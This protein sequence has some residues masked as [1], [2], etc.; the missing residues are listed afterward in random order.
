MPRSG[1]TLLKSCGNEP[2]VLTKDLLRFQLRDGRIVPTLLKPTPGHLALAGSL[3]DHWNGGVGKRLGELEDEAVPLLHESRALVVARGLQKLVLDRCRFVDAASAEHLRREALLASA[4][5]LRAPA[6]DADAHRAAIADGLGLDSAALAE[7]LYGDL[8][9][10]A[11]LAAGPDLDPGD[12]LAQYNLALCQGLLTHASELRITVHDAATGLRRKL[13]KALRWRRLLAHI[14]GDD[15]AAL[16]LVVSGPG[17]VLDQATRYGLQLALFLP[18]LAC[19]KRWS[20]AAT[21]KVPRVGGGSAVLT[22]DHTLDLPGDSAFLGHVP[23]ELRDLTTA[24]AAACPEWT[25]E[26][27]QLMPLSDGEIVVSD[28]QLRAD[29]A[30]WRIELFHRWHG[31][32]LARRLTQIA[33]GQ[34]PGLLLGVDRALARTAAVA[35]LLDD[36]LF[37]RRGFLFS[38]LLTPRGLREAVARAAGG[39][40]PASG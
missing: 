40:A 39:A 3:I 21:V 1:R 24:L 30:T 22:L 33:R 16:D 25:L 34:A 12:L 18:A 20:A 11:V 2:A 28:L 23:A 10:Q 4:A 36:P 27:P 26:D 15:G 13:L 37:A 32:A 7:R 31:S 8:P 29:G 19:A 6:T 14:A 17:S 38:D 9:D 5:A 35:P